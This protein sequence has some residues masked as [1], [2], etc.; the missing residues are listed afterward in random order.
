[1]SPLRHVVAALLFALLPQVTVLGGG[2]FCVAAGMGHQ[3]AAAQSP[4]P[5]HEHGSEPASDDSPRDQGPT[6]CAMAM[7][8]ATNGV[9]AAAVTALDPTVIRVSRI[10]ATNDFAPVSVRSAPDP[11]PP[12]I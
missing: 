8:C 4:V 11:P 1:M 3:A 9:V 12:R 5:M 6:H 10:T 2:A 7:S